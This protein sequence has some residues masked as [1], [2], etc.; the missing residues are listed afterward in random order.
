MKRVAIIVDKN[1]EMGAAANVTALLMGQLVMNNSNLY[2]DQPVVDQNNVQHAGIKYSTVIL[3]GG[4]NQIA[5]FSK[6]LSNNES[7]VKCVVFSE[8][9]QTLN[10]EF[11]V[12]KEKI[13]TSTLEETKPVG[14][15]VTGE[16]EEIRT[17]TKKF[18]VLK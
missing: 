4:K 8:T 6:S 10:N 17:L 13:T 7:S 15:I 3:K 9:G 1:L 14:V 12:Y 16:D 5:N 2:S 11:D 18:S